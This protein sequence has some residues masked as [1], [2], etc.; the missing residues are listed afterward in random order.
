MDPI[1][2]RLPV[3]WHEGWWLMWSK[4]CYTSCLLLLLCK[5]RKAACQDLSVTSEMESSTHF[6]QL[7]VQVPTANTQA[8][9]IIHL[10]SA[11]LEIQNGATQQTVEAVLLAL[12]SIY[13]VTSRLQE[14]STWPAVT[15]TCANPL[16]DWRLWLS[17]NSTWIHFSRRCFC[18]VEN[19]V[20]DWK[21]F[22]GKAMVL[23][24]SISVLKA[25]GFNG[26]GHNPNAVRSP[27]RNSAGWWRGSR[28]NK[29]VLSNRLFQQV[30]ADSKSAASPSL[31][32]DKEV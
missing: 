4:W 5:V 8:A 29:K 22:S 21:H 32:G 27:G 9:V 25:E 3:K 1:D 18:S 2:S 26:Q 12:K 17:S 19:V 15:Q 13:Q 28:Q 20:T 16:L 23:C 24:F 6:K 31:Y 11:T 10:P 14:K 7:E 30:S